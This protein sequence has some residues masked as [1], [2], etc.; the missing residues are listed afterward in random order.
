[1]KDNIKTKRIN[2]TI[3]EKQYKEIQEIIKNENRC[4]SISEF[5]RGAIQIQLDKIEQQE[6]FIGMNENLEK[7]SYMKGDLRDVGRLANSI[8]EWGLKTR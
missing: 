6:T 1:M 8:Q 7:I 4:L 5:I 3:L 2:I